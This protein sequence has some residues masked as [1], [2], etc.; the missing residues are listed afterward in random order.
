MP[1]GTERL[2]YLEGRVEEHATQLHLVN[3]AI[4]GLRAEMV[5]LRSEMAALRT[6]V[7][8]DFKWLVGLQV[9]TLLGVV[10]GM[11]SLYYRV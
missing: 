11:A 8:S 6:E 2:A 5:N 7:R 3:D 4:T 9:L 10:G 1:A